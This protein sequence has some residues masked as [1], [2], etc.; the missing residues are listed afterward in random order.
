MARPLLALVPMLGLVVA[1][2]GCHAPRSGAATGPAA[3]RY[4]PVTMDQ[5]AADSAH[6]PRLAEIAF[7][8]A[9]DRLNGLLYVAAGAGP[10]PVVLLLHGNPGNERNLDVA[11]AVRRAGYTVLYF[12]YRGNWGSGG[13]FSRTHA[14]EDVG[15]AL[16][17]VRSPAV[18][19]RFGIDPSRVALVGHSMGG[20]LALMSAAADPTVACVGS[21]D[22]R[23]VGA[24]GRHLRRDRAAESAL[25]AAND[26]LTAPGAP[27]RVE[28]GG[29]ALV[30]EMKVNAER[31]D[32]TGNARALKD[33]PVLLVA[34]AFTADQDTLA[35]A[36]GRAGA[37]RVTALAWPTDHSFSDR[38]LALA[39][40]VIDWLRSACAL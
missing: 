35:A 22:A 34:A 28:G 24:Y 21:L 31:W 10:H 26:S 8:S 12:D 3:V 33:R 7:Q 4:D 16:R 39:R 29:A 23:N 36:L 27:Y 1:A 30:T 18:A 20:W 13:S 25:V 15:A 37:R 38:R 6:P 2:F 17:W 5:P 9:G 11:Q 14:L 19:R 40:T 32:V